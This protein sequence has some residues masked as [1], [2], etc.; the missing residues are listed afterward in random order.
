MRAPDV[1]GNRGS[2]VRAWGEIPYRRGAKGVGELCLIPTAP[3]CALAYER[4]DGKARTSLPLPDTFYRKG[5]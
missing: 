1:S 3:A 2:L 5:F 4:L